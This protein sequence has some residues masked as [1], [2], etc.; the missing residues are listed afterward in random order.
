[1]G[2]SPGIGAL[3]PLLTVF[4]ELDEL[5]PNLF[6]SISGLF[7]VAGG[8]ITDSIGAEAAE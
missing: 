7:G 6:G 3:L 5:L 8:S 4:G 2:S 1:M